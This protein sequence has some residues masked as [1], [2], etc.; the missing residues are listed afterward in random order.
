MKK[1]QGF[2]LTEM[3]ITIAVAGIL[4]A[5]AIPSYQSHIRST[6]RGMA[7]ACLVQMSQFMERVYTSSMAYNSFNGSATQLPTM[8]CRTDLLDEYTFSMTADE[9]TYSVVATPRGSQAG[10][11]GC[12]ALS[13]NQ[14]GTRTANGESTTDIVKKCW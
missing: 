11:T 13:I 6:N 3:M 10:D 1:Q 2:S 8:Q 9:S 7:S 14:S 4:L 5:V 12:G